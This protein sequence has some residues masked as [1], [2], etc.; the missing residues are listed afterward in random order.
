M[1][2]CRQGEASED[3]SLPDGAAGGSAINKRFLAHP[4]RHPRHTDNATR[5]ALK[6]KPHVVGASFGGPA[7]LNEMR[8]SPD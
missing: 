7:Q 6:M 5:G 4:S 1:P 3:Q 2:P 8:R